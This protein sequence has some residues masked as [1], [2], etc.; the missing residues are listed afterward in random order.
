MAWTSWCWSSLDNSKVYLHWDPNLQQS[1]H[2]KEKEIVRLRQTQSRQLCRLVQ[3]VLGK[4]REGE[5]DVDVQCCVSECHHQCLLSP[6]NPN[7]SRERERN[8]SRHVGPSAPVVMTVLHNAN[9]SMQ[10]F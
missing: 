4:C 10:S 1:N 3:H 9:L 2:T 8:L 6:H 5:A 7:A